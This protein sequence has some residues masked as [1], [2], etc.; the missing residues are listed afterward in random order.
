MR[1]QLLLGLALAG[2]LAHSA[3]AGPVRLSDSQL[4]AVVAGTDFQVTNLIADRPGIARTTDPDLV[5]PWGL[6][7]AP[8]GPLWTANNGTGTSTVYDPNSFAKLGLTVW[9]PGANGGLGSP[10]GTVF[11]SGSGASFPVTQ[12]GVTGHSIFLFDTEDGTISGW[13]PTV[14]ANYAII[15]VNDSSTGAV[16]KGMTLVPVQHSQNLFAA[17]FVNNRVDMFN[18]QFQAIGSFTDASLPTGYAPFNVQTLNGQVYV[19]FAK[20]GDGHDEVDGHG[21]GYI[22]IYNTHG[23]FVHRLVAKGPL[24]APWGLAIAPASFGEFAGALLVGNFG[25]GVIVAFNPTTGAYLGQLS[26]HGK[27]IVIPGLWALA[28]GPDGEVIFSSG[29]NGEANGLI[30][31][32]KPTVAA[33]SWAFRAHATH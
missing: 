25:S 12:N 11:T 30:G 9:I 15:A 1:T 14:N 29:P 13:A 19:A 18:G 24:N 33:A 28:Q 27:P 16:F 4:N 6:S 21:L 2:S 7:S 10:T 8:G 26:D 3:L 31:A 22:D 5:N 20:R 17:D 32:I 23:Q